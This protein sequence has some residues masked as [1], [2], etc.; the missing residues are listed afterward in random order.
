MVTLFEAWDRTTGSVFLSESEKSELEQDALPMPVTKKGQLMHKKAE[1]EK[2]RE[3]S[4]EVQFD[5]K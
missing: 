4:K 1:K 2:E 5:F 3:K